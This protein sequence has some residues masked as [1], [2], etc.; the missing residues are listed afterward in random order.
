[1]VIWEQLIQF[2]DLSAT[3]TKFEDLDTIKIPSFQIVQE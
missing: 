1:M 2:K 3:G